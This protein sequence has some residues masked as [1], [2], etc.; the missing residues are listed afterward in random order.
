MNQKV[1]AVHLRI[2]VHL[3]K[4]KRK[5]VKGVVV[6]DV[7]LL[8]VDMGVVTCRISQVMIAVQIATLQVA[9][10]AAAKHAHVVMGL[11]N[12]LIF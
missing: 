1:V 3:P 6:G 11:E 4:L 7:L 10:Q 9:L 5:N 12:N 8:M 2:V